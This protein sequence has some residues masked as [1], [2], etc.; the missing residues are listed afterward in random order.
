[1]VDAVSVEG[2]M[3]EKD[4]GIKGVVEKKRKETV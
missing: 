1:M 2:R 3:L 4:V